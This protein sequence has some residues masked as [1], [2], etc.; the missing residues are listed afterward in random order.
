[1]TDSLI[2]SGGVGGVRQTLH[3]SL[4]LGGCDKKKQHTR[5]QKKNNLRFLL[6]IPEVGGSHLVQHR[7]ACE[8]TVMGWIDLFPAAS[9]GT[10]RIASFYLRLCTRP[11][12]SVYRSA[13]LWCEHS[14]AFVSSAQVH[15]VR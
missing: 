7:Q 3:G 14:R 9:Y 11:W 13:S 12:D 8:Y 2:K 6:S 1:M 4:K 10:E 5:T 15:G